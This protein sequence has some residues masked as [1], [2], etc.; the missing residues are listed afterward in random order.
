VE[1]GKRYLVPG[2]I[3]SQLAAELVLPADPRIG[4]RSRS[5]KSKPAGCWKDTAGAT[6]TAG[7]DVL[8]GHIAIENGE[9]SIAGGS[10]VSSDGGGPGG[11]CTLDCP[12]RT[13]GRRAKSANQPG[14]A[15]LQ[16]GGSHAG[17]GSYG[18]EDPVTHVGWELLDPA[19]PAPGGSP[20]PRRVVATPSTTPSIRRTPA[21]AEANSTSAG[22]RSCHIPREFDSG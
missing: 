18:C 13:V 21:A 3:G 8:A 6:L 17:Y 4:G 5:A 12:L 2:E 1:A 16:W 20:R 14:G 15:S 19:A 22:R 11:P 7:A 10:A 9:M